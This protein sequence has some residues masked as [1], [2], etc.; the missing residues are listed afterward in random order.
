MADY[1][2]TNSAA[3]IGGEEAAVAG[4]FNPAFATH[5]IRKPDDSFF[6]LP[7]FGLNEVWVA[8]DYYVPTRG[9]GEDGLVWEYRY[10]NGNP[11]FLVE[12]SNGGTWMQRR[13]SNASGYTGDAYTEV[14]G[15]RTRVDIHIIKDD[16]GTPGNCTFEIYFDEGLAYHY[17]GDRDTANTHLLADEIRIGGTDHLPDGTYMY[18]SNVR[19]S[20]SDTRGKNFQVVPLA[21]VGTYDEFSGGFGN[22]LDSGA[23]VYSDAAGERI[24]GTP[25]FASLVD[26]GAPTSV[27]VQSMLYAEAANPNPNSMQHFLRDGGVNYDNAV[28]HTPS[29]MRRR[30]VSEWPINPATGL[31]WTHADL[32]GM[33]FGLLS[34]QV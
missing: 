13:T 3:D 33:E 26:N 27:R 2:L 18:L 30:Y 20:D 32:D 10:K 25:N 17:S 12:V 1:L 7:L 16:V 29:G 6:V 34:S 11:M 9:A 8:F 24:S 4:T 28:V 22:L 19:V 31:A 23:F 5:A 15:V 21:V 14:T